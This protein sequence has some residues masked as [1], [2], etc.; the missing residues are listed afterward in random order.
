LRAYKSPTRG[1]GWGEKEGEDSLTAPKWQRKLL[2]KA[3]SGKKYPG[4]VACTREKWGKK[5]EKSNGM[6]NARAGQE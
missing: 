6:P 4:K 2:L 5:E 1:R 3:N